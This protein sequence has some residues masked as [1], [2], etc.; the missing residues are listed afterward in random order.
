MSR[1]VSQEHV[2]IVSEASGFGQLSDEVVQTIA[3]DLEY[4]LR[5]LAQESAKF[6]R[7]AKRKRLT[8]NDV[9][10]ALVA[11]NMEPIHGYWSDPQVESVESLFQK[12]KQADIYFMPDEQLNLVALMRS[13]IPK[14]PSQPRMTSH[15]LAVEGVQPATPNNPPLS[16]PLRPKKAKEEAPTQD[17]PTQEEEA[18]EAAVTMPSQHVLSYEQHLLLRTIKEAILGE[19]ESSKA[20]ALE[21]L[22]QDSGLS[23]LVPYFI[24]FITDQATHKMDDIS[25]ISSILRMVDALFQN[26]TIYLEPYLH[27]LMPSLITCVVART[28]GRASDDHVACRRHASKLIAVACARYN[29]KYPDL[30]LRIQKT[31]VDALIPKRSLETHFGALLGLRTLGPRVIHA[32]L[33]PRLEGYFTVLEKKRR[34]KEFLQ[35]IKDLLKDALAEAKHEVMKELGPDHESLVKYDALQMKLSSDS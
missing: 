27:Q 2:R 32:V 29:A 14:I 28:I 3:A 24:T 8:T 7:H 13:A 9:N 35:K 25:V 33:L 34:N 18:A 19:E 6:V 12:V 11:R 31:F 17:Q 20:N 21:S 22:T 15:W 4:R 23:Q 16:V 30:Q 1:F 10:S 5:E 26:P